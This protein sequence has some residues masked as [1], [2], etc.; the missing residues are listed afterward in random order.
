[1]YANTN[2]R[3]GEQEAGP[4]SRKGGRAGRLIHHSGATLAARESGSALPRHL[5]ALLLAFGFPLDLLLRSCPN[6]AHQTADGTRPAI[7]RP[8][9]YHDVRIESSFGHTGAVGVQNMITRRRLLAGGLVSVAAGFVSACRARAATI[10]QKFEVTHTDAEWR[11]LLTARA[12][13][14]PSARRN[15]ASIHQPSP[16]RVATGNVRLRRVQPQSILLGRQSSRATPV[17]R[18]SGRRSTRQSARRRITPSASRASPSSAGDAAGIRAMCSTMVR[19]QTGL[20]YCINGVAL[21]FR[22]QT[23]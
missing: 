23:A 11:Q 13:R 10:A 9:P 19:S 4:D 8:G 14:R 20:R 5:L 18:A 1:M 16:A 3:I 21:V 22:P 7:T 6:A 2:R 15:R 17:G 12:V